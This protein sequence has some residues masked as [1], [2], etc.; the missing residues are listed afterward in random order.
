MLEQI[1]AQGFCARGVVIP[2][3]DLNKPPI[4]I[5]GASGLMT[6]GAA[7]LA[8]GFSVI[9]RPTSPISGPEGANAGAGPRAIRGT[10]SLSKALAVAPSVG[11][12]GPG[13]ATGT[14]EIGR[15]HV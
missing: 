8:A 11:T 5:L 12:T 3:C 15:A 7:G 13:S 2:P 4:G 6:I 1:Q 9:A 10:R 14:G